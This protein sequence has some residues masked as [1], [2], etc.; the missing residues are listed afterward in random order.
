M[1]KDTVDSTPAIVAIDMDSTDFVGPIESHS[2]LDS[3]NVSTNP[4]FLDFLGQRNQSNYL[5]RGINEID[6]ELRKYDDFEGINQ[7]PIGGEIIVYSQSIINA[8][9]LLSHE[10]NLWDPPFM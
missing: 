1:E 9:F 7:A 4:Y 6:H 5:L 3:P 10:F 8:Y 2:I